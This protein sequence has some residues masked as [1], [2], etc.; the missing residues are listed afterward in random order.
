MP[1]MITWSNC[2]AKSAA[3]AVRPSTNQE[4]RYA[5][6]NGTLA[7]RIADYATHQGIKGQRATTTPV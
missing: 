7:M 6:A 3:A 4:H 5:I 2:S 1:N